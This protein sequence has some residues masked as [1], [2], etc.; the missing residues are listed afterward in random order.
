MTIPQE[1]DT[2]H[3]IEDPN[4]LSCYWEPHA[5]GDAEANSSL[6]LP[7]DGGN[8]YV[9]LDG[10]REVPPLVLIHGLAASSRWWDPLVPLLT[11][12]YRVIRID[13]LGHGKSSK[14]AGPGYRIAEHA[15]RVG[16]ALDRLGVKRAIVVGHS[17]G[18]SVA[19][20][21]AEQRRAQV[22]ALV[23]VDSYPCMEADISEGPLS[24]LLPVPVIGHLLWLLLTGPLTRKAMTT[25]F[26]RGFDIPQ[27][28]IDDMRGNTYHAFTATSQGAVDYLE[29]RSL[30]KRLAV[31]DTP[32]LVIFGEEDQRC[33]S[34]FANQYRA[35]PGARVELL[36]GLGHSPMV[37]DPS[38]TAALLHVFAE[39]VRGRE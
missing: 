39:S 1:L 18:G 35:V 36:N 7:L 38:R 32:L 8:M 10:R 11:T 37:E 22:K 2:F 33:R 14:P 4:P 19:T 34:S 5:R 24:R 23:L 15:Q 28:L 29:Q 20:A 30:P 31:L 26:S 17:T 9:R 16:A 27:P 13:M 21:L 25:G 3:Q 12:S 6:L